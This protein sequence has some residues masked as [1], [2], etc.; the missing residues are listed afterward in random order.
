ML[1]TDCNHFRVGK[2]L[3]KADICAIVFSFLFFLFSL[4]FLG[5]IPSRYHMLACLHLLYF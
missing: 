4:I 5:V 2:A 3:E 1:W